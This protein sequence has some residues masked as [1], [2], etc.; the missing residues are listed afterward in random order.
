MAKLVQSRAMPVNRL[1]IGLRRRNLHEIAVA[2]V[3]GALTA[4]A[5]VRLRRAINA[6]ASGWIMSGARGGALA[7]MPSGKPSH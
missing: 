3:E 2:I 4:D 1:E 7:A 6:S 5:K